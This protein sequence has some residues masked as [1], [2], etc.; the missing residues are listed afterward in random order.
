M[1]NFITMKDMIIIIKGGGRK[2]WKVMDMFMAWTLVMD[3][4]CILIELYT[5][6]MYS[7]LH[8]I[9]TSIKLLK[10]KRKSTQQFLIGVRGTSDW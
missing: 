8:I 6:N 3:S 9:L 2:L 1:L 4:W 5:L 7:F 10:E